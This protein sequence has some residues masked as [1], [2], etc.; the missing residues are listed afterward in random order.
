MYLF[1]CLYVLATIALYTRVRSGLK[2]KH[3]KKKKENKIKKGGNDPPIL[4]LL[5]RILTLLFDC[6]WIIDSLP[7]FSISSM[8]SSSACYMKGQ[9]I[10]TEHY[11]RRNARAY[12][13]SIRILNVMCIATRLG[14]D[15]SNLLFP[16]QAHKRVQNFETTHASAFKLATRSVRRLI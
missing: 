1:Y 8:G 6:L 15:F 2:A 16:A 11:V 3:S 10:V 9:L 14:R 13:D 4:P 12:A 7:F 5:N